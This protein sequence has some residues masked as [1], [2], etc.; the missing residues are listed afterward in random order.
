MIKGFKEFIMQG[1]V[2]DLA[3]AVVIGAAFTGIV[4]AIV[5]SFINPLI[6]AFVPSGDLSAWTIDIPG[7]FAT[8]KFGIGAIISAAINFLAV[9][10]VVYFFL[11]V[12][13]K[14]V[15]DRQSAK[16]PVVEDVPSELTEQD[17]LIQIRDLLSQQA[18]GSRRALR[19]STDQ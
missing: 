4:T 6:G 19:A 13:M 18:P 5:E 12:P 8:A 17:V 3:V 11:V 1:N 10:L 7:I 14:R 16:A 15:K 9:A 2:I